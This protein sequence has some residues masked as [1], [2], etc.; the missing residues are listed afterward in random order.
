MTLAWKRVVDPGLSGY[1]FDI[2]T[3][4]PGDAFSGFT[5]DTTNIPVV[6]P[7]DR[8][9]SIPPRYCHIRSPALADGSNWWFSVR[10]HDHYGNLSPSLTLGPYKIDTIPPSSTGATVT[11]LFPS[12]TSCLVGANQVTGTWTGFSDSGSG[13]ARFFCSLTN[14]LP[15]ANGLW[16]T[17]S[18]AILSGLNPDATNV[19]HVRAMDNAG[20]I[21]TADSKPFLVL[22]SYGDWDGDGMVNSSEA[23]A[24]TDP[25]A[26]ASL[27]H[28]DME[29]HLSNS[30]VVLQWPSSSNRLYTL[31]HSSSLLPK[32]SN[33]TTFTNGLRIPGLG[34]IMSWTDRVENI[35]ARFYRI[36]VEQP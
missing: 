12:D 6:L 13:I 3:N 24:G 1:S 14:L 26:A 31:T 28:L 10:A 35:P 16:T 18:S 11:L 21:S 9:S 4:S 34:G 23:I 5:P 30:M 7:D 32:S 27:L 36:T 22:T 33:W 8:W 29:T 15:S 25:A 20:L 2:W 19:F 17:S